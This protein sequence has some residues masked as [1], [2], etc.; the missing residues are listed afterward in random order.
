MMRPMICDSCVRFDRYLEH[1]D[2]PATCTS[3][4][5]G[6]P[7]DIYPGGGDH[8]ESRSGEEPWELL[9]GYEPFLEAYESEPETP[10]D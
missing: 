9:E 6:I 7:R 1:P 2:V 8:R 3:F 4:P 10:D 5:Q